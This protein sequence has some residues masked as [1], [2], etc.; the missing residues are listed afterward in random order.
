MRPIV[1]TLTV[2]ALLI[3][4]IIYNYSVVNGYAAELRCR[5]EALPE[6]G[7][8]ECTSQIRDLSDVWSS[9]RSFISF[10]VGISALQN[11][12]DLLDSLAVA[13]EF[14]TRYDFERYRALLI[15]AFDG[16]AQFESFSPEDIF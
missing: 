16:L 12:D 7:S 3:S 8:V 9:H 2:L 10:S 11:I 15:N 5:A 13:A 14:G 1:I 6:H 4:F